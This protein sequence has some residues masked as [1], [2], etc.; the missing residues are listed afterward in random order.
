MSSSLRRVD[1]RGNMTPSQFLAGHLQASGRKREHEKHQVPCL[2]GGEATWKSKHQEG[3]KTQEL[4]GG[5]YCF[6]SISSGLLYL[7]GS[8]AVIKA[9][10]AA[11]TA[12]S[13]FYTGN[14][15]FAPK[16]D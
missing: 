16:E 8:G 3:T 13:S 2:R 15:I 1:P 10:T 12:Q 11:I 6:C 7:F 5:I 4:T 9:V 14:T